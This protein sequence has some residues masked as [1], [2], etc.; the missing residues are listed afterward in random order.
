M[1][2]VRWVGSSLDDLR[3]VPPSVRRDIGHALFTAQRGQI[4]PAAKPLKGFGGASIMEIV[5]THQRGSWRAVYTVRFH[6]VIYVLHVFQKKS[7]KG[8]Q[9]PLREM[10]L[11]RQ[12]LAE[13]E[14]DYRER[15]HGKA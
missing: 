5:A 8:I 1:K 15:G 6:D 3:S 4:D 12:R 2:T 11:I 14:R 9:T 10:H 7:T 13:A